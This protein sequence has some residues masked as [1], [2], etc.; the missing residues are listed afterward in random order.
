MDDCQHGVTFVADCTLNE[1]QVLE[2]LKKHRHPNIVGYH[3]CVVTDGR[4]T[5]I[6]LQRCQSNIVEHLESCKDPPDIAKWIDEI[7]TGIDLLHS[8]GMAHNDINPGHVY[9]VEGRAVIIDFDSCLPFGHSL[10]K[11][12][13][14]AHDG[15]SRPLSAAQN[16]EQGLRDLQASLAILVQSTT[17]PTP[18][19]GQSAYL[20]M[21]LAPD[22]AQ[23]RK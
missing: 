4:I 10:M 6:S 8:L 18:D 7:K 17:A 21:Q 12:C 16:D 20:H 5:Q 23:N 22:E 13:S 2:I 15:D 3:G 9:I 1:I 14:V 11:G 19:R